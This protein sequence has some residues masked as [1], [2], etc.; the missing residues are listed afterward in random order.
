MRDT[1]IVV[2]RR[3]RSIGVGPGMLS[4]PL[5]KSVLLVLGFSGRLAA[6]EAPWFG[7]RT[8]GEPQVTNL[9]KNVAAPQRH[10][11]DEISFLKVGG[12]SGS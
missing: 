5:V 4:G 9:L 2:R 1:F 11:T 10:T 8:P 7:P 3:D 6:L 12:P